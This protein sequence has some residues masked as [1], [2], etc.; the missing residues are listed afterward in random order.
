M[1]ER[2]DDPA[3]WRLPSDAFAAQLAAARHTL[4]AA[5]TD[6]SAAV[7]PFEPIIEELKYD[8]AARGVK[9]PRVRALGRELFAELRATAG[10]V[11]MD[12]RHYCWHLQHLGELS[13]LTDVLMVTVTRFDHYARHVPER[14]EVC[15][16]FLGDLP[17]QGA[18]GGRA[19]FEEW[20][21][22]RGG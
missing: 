6:P 7:G 20:L 3:D 13:S 11:A 4:L 16:E 22:R 19:H 21:R 18:P 8:L 15:T 2:P 17:F 9:L 1:G 5:R 10:P 12:V 14:C